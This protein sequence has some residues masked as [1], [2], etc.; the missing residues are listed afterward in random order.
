MTTWDATCDNSLTYL[1]WFDDILEDFE[2]TTLFLMILGHMCDD[3]GA[4][5]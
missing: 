2:G 3:F 5:T 4:R 1:N